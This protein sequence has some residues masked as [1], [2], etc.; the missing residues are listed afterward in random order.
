MPEQTHAGA[1]PSAPGPPAMSSVQTERPC[2]LRAPPGSCFA[3]SLSEC[4]SS[5]FLPDGPGHTACPLT[6]WLPL[7]PCS[8]A[9]YLNSQWVGRSDVCS[10][11]P[12]LLLGVARVIMFPVC[13]G[14]APWGGGLCPP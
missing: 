5:A 6:G 13:Y 12:D 2:P 1:R 8:L 7:G 14:E 4:S 9:R 11:L 10:P 3:C